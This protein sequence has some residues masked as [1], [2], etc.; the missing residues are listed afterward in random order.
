M[1]LLAQFTH[2]IPI[3]PIYP[4]VLYFSSFLSVINIFL[5]LT[6]RSYSKKSALPLFY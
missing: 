5:R 4:K 6:K 3:T 1:A 2:I